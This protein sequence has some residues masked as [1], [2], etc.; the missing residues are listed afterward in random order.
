[1]HVVF[2]RSVKLEDFDDMWMTRVPFEYSKKQPW[3]GS[4]GEPR[5]TFDAFLQGL[6]W[7][8][9]APAPANLLEV[10]SLRTKR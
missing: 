3:Y 4:V 1:V 2:G 5:E 9:L 6:H 7:A 10:K 8:E